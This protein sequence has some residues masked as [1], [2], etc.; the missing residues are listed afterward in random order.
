[1]CILIYQLHSA[2]AKG[3]T[4]NTEGQKHTHTQAH[5][6]ANKGFRTTTARTNRTLRCHYSCLQDVVIQAKALP[7][8]QCTEEIYSQKPWVESPAPSAK[9]GH[10]TLLSLKIFYS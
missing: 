6:Y 7:K 5:T 3:Q 10:S 1:M 9:V 2:E 8:A 4:V